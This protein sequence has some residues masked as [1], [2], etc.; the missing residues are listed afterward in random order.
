[1]INTVKN[2][3][4][5]GPKVNMRELIDNGAIIVDVRTKGEYAGGNINGSLNIPLDQ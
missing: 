4:G 5:L 1:M 3:L 2:F